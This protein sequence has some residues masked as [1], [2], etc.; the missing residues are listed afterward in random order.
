MKPPNLNR[1]GICKS[2]KTL[3]RFFVFKSLIFLILVGL[4]LSNCMTR[5][6]K[7]SSIE[8]LVGDPGEKVTAEKIREDLARY[9][10]IMKSHKKTKSRTARTGTWLKIYPFTKP[11]AIAT[12]KETVNQSA[13]KE[14]WSEA[15]KQK[16]LQKKLMK[17]EEMATKNETCFLAEINADKSEATQTK[18]WHGQLIQGSQ[19]TD[20]NFSDGTGFSSRDV[21]T[22]PDHNSQNNTST[23][24]TTYYHFAQICAPAKIDFVKAF[25]LKIEP[26]YEAGLLPTEFV[27]E[28]PNESSFR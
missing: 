14:K 4:G 1:A 20:M 11:L 18:Y 16:E 22:H 9:G 6:K 23:S 10:H 8:A 3:K 19:S 7:A 17:A 28:K 12:A 21:K 2:L 13:F 25:R 26:R 5:E 15:K 24:T 27:W